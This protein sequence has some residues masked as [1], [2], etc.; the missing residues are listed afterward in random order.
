MI[1][2]DVVDIKIPAPETIS[3]EG[4]N[5]YRIDEWGNKHLRV[6]GCNA[7]FD[8]VDFD[9]NIPADINEGYELIDGKLKKVK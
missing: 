2:A 1:V 4:K 9:G 8:V 5:A 7:G 3:I 6:G